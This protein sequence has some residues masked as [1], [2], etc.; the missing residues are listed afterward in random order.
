M[1]FVHLHTHTHYTF[2]RSLGNPEAL[3]KRAK[4][5]WQ[6]AIA[7]TDAGN[8]YGAFEFYQA[9]KN[10]WV[11][12]IIWVEFTIS[13]RWRTNRDKDNELYEIV[14]L[15]EN[16][17]GYK[18]LINLVTKSQLEGYYNGRARIDFDLL[19]EYRSDIIALSGSMYGEIGQHI[20]T[21]K[22]DDFIR[23]RIEYYQSLFWKEKYFL[24]IEEHLDKP[25]QSKINETILRLAKMYGYE[26]VWTNNSYYITLEDAEIQDM[27]ASVADGRALDD[28]DRPTLMGW[29]YSIRP[30]REMEEIL[31][32]APKAYENSQKIADMIDLTIDYGGYKIPKFPLSEEQEKKY[33]I[34]SESIWIEEEKL[35][36]EEWFL[37]TL[38]IEGL[39]SRY[40]FWLEESEQKVLVEKLSQKPIGKKV[41]EMSVE[42][43]YQLSE[44]YYSS[45]KKAII[46][47]LDDEK[48]NIIKRLEY[49]L[50]VVNLMGFN[51]YFCIVADFIR[52]GKENGVPVWPGRGSAAGAILAYLSGI[53]DID[54]LKYGLLFER[55]LNPARITMP[56]IDVDFSDDGREKVLQYV[57]QKYG[58]DHVTQVCTFGTLAARA[59]VKDAGRAL[60]VSFA[61]MNEFAKLIPGK[62]G[63]TLKWALEEAVEFKKAYD[64][65][66]LYKKVIDAALR[67]EWSV[68]QLW[69]HACAV[70][71]APEPMTH[72][73][74]LQPPP[75]DP[76]S[77]VTQF[78]AWPLEALGLLK[79]DFLGLKNLTILARA[80][81]IVK[82]VHEK[83]IDLLRI[84]Y[85]D[86]KVLALFGEGDMTGVFQF[87][88]AG[89]RRY[90]KE[91][92]PS[93]FEDLIAMVSLYR[94]GPMPFIPDFIDRKHG[95]KIVEYPHPSLEAILKPTYGIAV[96]QEQVMQLVQAF[97]GFSLGEA[98]I[99]RRAIGKKKYELL[100]EQRWK[101]IEA[102]K[103]NW[104]KEELA[105]YIFDEIIEPFAG[106]GFNKSHAACYAMIAY[107]T[108]YMKTYF[109]TEFMVAL[110]VSDEEDT[111]RIRLEIEEAKEKWVNIL[112]PDVNES[113]RHFTFIDQKNIRFWLQA[114][115]GIGDG[116]IHSIREAVK[117]EK[118]KNIYD[119]I[120]RTG[121]DTIN[122][123][124]LESLILSGALDA[125]G[126]RASLMASIPKMTAY[127]KEIESK[128]ETAQIGLFDLWGGV[129]GSGVHFDLAKV[130]P[131]SF[132]DR[133][134][135]EKSMIGYPVSGH[136][137]DG[138]ADFI[139]SKTKN[140]WAIFDWIE[141]KWSIKTDPGMVEIPTPEDDWSPGLMPAEI[142]ATGESLISPQP[143]DITSPL[144]DEDTPPI[145]IED[146]Q[147]KVTKTPSESVY[148]QLIGLVH[149]VRKF[150][151]KTGGMMLIAT[152]ESVGFDFKL[153]IFPRDYDTYA[154]KIEEDRI[155]VV[156]GRVKFDEERD[157]ISISPSTGFGKKSEPSGSIKSFGI[158]QFREMAGAKDDMSLPKYHNWDP[159]GNGAQSEQKNDPRYIIS[160]PA[161]WTKEDLLDLRDFLEKSPIWLTPVWIS[162]GGK[163][164]DTKF[165]IENITE[166]KEWVEKRGG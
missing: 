58:S 108:A 33:K 61:E 38:C 69:V 129:T 160:V 98:D 24:E 136:P 161:F 158:S 20:I 87:E 73:C 40:T 16:Y 162:I 117:K 95:R 93:A 141:N 103:K 144:S 77:V 159:L 42:E 70:I 59:A 122:K 51:W 26:Y 140:L 52:Y 150:Q 63:T 94:P 37:R 143:D 124:S 131:L 4:E 68:R 166:L 44:S 84:D 123:K 60:G 1:P 21:G 89:M 100:M 45:E 105:I 153:T 10:E 49:E 57:R 25:M 146:V 5:L 17:T 125:F 86:P 96:Y 165:T 82:D 116:P 155:L 15:A 138:I 41:S 35:W 92:K 132:E 48:K 85:E 50:T 81:Q 47:S 99:L 128:K 118:F 18:N 71:I 78:S 22:S 32:Y 112:P 163:E 164:K 90:L 101:F 39:N 53:T 29:D 88:S 13:K 115:K 110:L 14:L 31:V 19:E 130:P 142:R 75:K 55:F 27:M 12:P 154:A 2:Q 134:K 79:M 62:P 91:L 147:M 139:R 64:E 102:A 30:S 9:C 66:P 113:R 157:E 11:K 56:D 145:D 107:Q 43:L 151:T 104:N 54:P 28:P 152:V 8:L 97:A 109:P 67:L 111:D 133:M 148:A 72:F 121:G 149:D 119:F 46:A 137:L 6:S 126:E 23:E 36:T 76:H 34:Y 114:I 156:D 80:I 135:W 127:L 65:N 3:A 7:I 74:P 120:E 83:D 106:Y